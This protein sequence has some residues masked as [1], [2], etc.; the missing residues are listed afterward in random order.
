MMFRT[1][2]KWKHHNFKT[3]LNVNSDDYSDYKRFSNIN[4]QIKAKLSVLHRL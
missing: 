1:V 4:S 2:Q 3:P